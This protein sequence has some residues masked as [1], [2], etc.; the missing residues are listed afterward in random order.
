MRIYDM[1]DDTLFVGEELAGDNDPLWVT[2][3]LGGVVRYWGTK[4]GRGQLAMD[5]PTPAT[6]VDV[7]PRGSTINMLHVKRVI[8][9]TKKAEEQWT[10]LLEALL[11]QHEGK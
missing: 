1:V 11:Q 6:V 5:G 8:N 4:R 2:C 9:M 10:N 7:E 3:G